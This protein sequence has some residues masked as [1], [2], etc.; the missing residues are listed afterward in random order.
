MSR[1][2]L[3]QGLMAWG[4]GLFSGRAEPSAGQKLDPALAGL[5]ADFPDAL[6]HEEARRLGLDPAR[7]SREEMLQTVLAAMQPKA[8]QQGD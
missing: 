7:H 5:A 3:F 1:K 4:T 6:L 2:E 8:P